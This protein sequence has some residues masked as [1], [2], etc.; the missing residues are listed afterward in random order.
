[1]ALPGFHPT[2][3]MKKFRL[4]GLTRRS[5]I[6]KEVILVCRKQQC[7]EGI[8]HSDNFPHSQ[9]NDGLMINSRGILEILCSSEQVRSVVYGFPKLDSKGRAHWHGV[10]GKGGIQRPV[11][12]TIP[13]GQLI[14]NCQP[15]A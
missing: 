7:P 1:M 10:T 9:V 4:R 8:P 15:G 14:L 13:G 6:H 5:L 11:S 12:F 2:T 3:I